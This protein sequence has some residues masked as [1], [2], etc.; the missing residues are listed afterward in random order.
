MSTKR[1]MAESFAFPDTLCVFDL[2]LVRKLCIK[3]PTATLAGLKEATD[4]GIACLG[5]T[6]H[7]LTI[8]ATVDNV[9]N[10]TGIFYTK[11]AS[12]E[13]HYEDQSRDVN[14]KMLKITA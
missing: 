9:V 4:E 3:M 14:N 6:K 7:R 12:H 10:S 8:I 11:T 5:C 1:G 2:P 13:G